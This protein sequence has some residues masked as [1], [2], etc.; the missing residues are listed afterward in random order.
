[1]ERFDI[2]RF[3]ILTRDPKRGNNCVGGEMIVWEIEK[4]G[5]K[6][7][8]GGIN[9]NVVVKEIKREPHENWIDLK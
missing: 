2:N 6:N 3:F 9:W 7:E 8:A 1:M 5:K 4:E